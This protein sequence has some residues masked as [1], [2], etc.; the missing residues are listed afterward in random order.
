MIKMKLFAVAL[1]A[2]TPAIAEENAP[3]W[4]FVH[5]ASS[6]EAEGSKVTMPVEREIFAFTDRP[7][8]LHAHLNAHEYV[9]LWNDDENSFRSVPPNAVLTWVADGVMQEAEVELLGAEISDL[10]R[11]ISY[12]IAFETGTS[13]PQSA[14]YASLF[15]DDY[16]GKVR[17]LGSITT[18]KGDVLIIGGS[19]NCSVELNGTCLDD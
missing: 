8:R 12:D 4:L 16:S 14:D 11:T 10:G 13:L 2:A 19:G 18:G 9:S 5:T 1:L 17:N 15:V 7:Y 6:F 3:S